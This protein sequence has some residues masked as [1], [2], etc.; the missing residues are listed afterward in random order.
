MASLPTFL[1]YTTMHTLCTMPRQ[2]AT[3]DTAV[4]PLFRS[5]KCRHAASLSVAPHTRKESN[6]HPV[7]QAVD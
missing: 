3:L 1:I 5:N 7:S 6:Y 2:L 4:K